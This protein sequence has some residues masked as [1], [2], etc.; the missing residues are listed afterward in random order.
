MT[1]L[2]GRSRGREHQADRHLLQSPKA[3]EAD[4]RRSDTWRVLRIMGELV[5]G[6][7]ELA[8]KVEE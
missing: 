8:A 7:E 4:F 3:G 6:F 2:S 1:S 5:E